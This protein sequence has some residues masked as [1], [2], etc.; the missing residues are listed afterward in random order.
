MAELSD[1]LQCGFRATVAHICFPSHTHRTSL[2]GHNFP[3]NLYSQLVWTT[4]PGFR[5]RLTGR[6]DRAYGGEQ[7]SPT[8]PQVAVLGEGGH[9]GPKT[10]PAPTP[11]SQAGV[12]RMQKPKGDAIH[13]GQ[14]YGQ[15]VRRNPSRLTSYLWQPKG[16][17]RV[18]LSY[19]TL[20]GQKTAR[21]GDVPVPSVPSAALPGSRL[22]YTNRCVQWVCLSPRPHTQLCLFLTPNR[23]K[24]PGSIIPC[25]G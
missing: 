8:H 4:G 10:L 21:A 1:S 7:R 18:S 2:F 19:V 17:V 3:L 22:A 25:S 20:L 5:V 14:D 15:L 9:L 24:E 13:V 23:K 11:T 6:R 16:P 12:L